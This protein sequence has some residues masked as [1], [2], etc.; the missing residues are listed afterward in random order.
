MDDLLKV[1]PGDLPGAEDRF[2]RLRRIRWWRQDRLR[3]ARVL[4]VGAGALGNEI[5][6]NLALL[7]VGNLLIADRDNIENSNLSR[8]VLFRASDNGKRKAEVAAREAQDLFPDLQVQWFHGNATT[9]LGLGVYRW[10]DIVIAGLDNRE[11]RL[12]VNASAL[13]AGVPWVDGAIEELN[14]VMRFFAPGEGAC[15]EC[16]M[17]EADWQMVH[18]RR[19]CSLLTREEMLGGRVP[20]TPTTASIVAGL[21]VQEAVKY[22]HGLP[23]LAGKGVQFNGHTHDTYV[24]EYARKADCPAHETWAPVVELP[25][26]TADPT[27]AELLARVR[28]D[29]GPGASIELAQEF[30]VAL[31]C[32]ACGRKDAFFGPLDG[33]PEEKATCPACGGHRAPELTHV[34][35]GEEP[36]LELCPAEIGVP[37]YDLVLGRAG[38]QRRAYAFAGDREAALGAAG[39]NGR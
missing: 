1:A 27:L 11:A 6:K 31:D 16:T 19:A 39:R 7:G 35:R 33:V 8:S 28:G 30:V 18:R 21:Q 17:N 26:G 5:V 25:W 10:A 34:L 23:V 9:A 24:I 14:G 2:D 13:R 37:P 15:Y 29:L 4:V 38:E 3:E 32:G 22:L 12:A 36:F 20:T